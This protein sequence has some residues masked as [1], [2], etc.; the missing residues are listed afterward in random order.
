MLVLCFGIQKSGSTLAFELVKG[1]LQTAGFE[2][3]F[4][5]NERFKDGAPIPPSARNYIEGVTRQKIEELAAE[6]GPERRIAVK[7]HGMFADAMFP[8][9]EEMQARRKL[10]VIVSWR[11]PRDV[12]LSLL[13]AGERSRRIEAGAFT[14]LKTLDDAAEY[15][16]RRIASYRKWATLRGALR[17]DYDTVAYEPDKAI[18]AMEKV[19]GVT[20][21]RVMAKQHAFEEADTR[22]NKARR[23][24]YRAEMT[25][26]QQAEL[27]KTFR[28]FL[29]ESGD[30]LSWREQFRERL[31]AGID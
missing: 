13:D 27:E 21:N 25:G 30:D 26:E 5:R 6:I 4:L 28:R 22:K 29:K 12:C 8:W 17:L 10:Q 2:Q 15:V 14:E 20:G 11:D 24:R 9:L 31:L 19:L 16:R 1:V 7:T 23:D 3:T 18:D